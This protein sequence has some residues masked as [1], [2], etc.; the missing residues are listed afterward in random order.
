[1]LVSFGPLAIHDFP[2]LSFIRDWFPL[3]QQ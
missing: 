3:P 2:E 1:V